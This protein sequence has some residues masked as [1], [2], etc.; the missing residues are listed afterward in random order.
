MSFQQQLTEYRSKHSNNLTDHQDT[1]DDGII[2]NEDLDEI[3]PKLNGDQRLALEWIKAGKNVLITGQAGT[4]KSMVLGEVIKWLEKKYGL[5]TGLSNMREEYAITSMTGISSVNIGGQTLHSWAGI[6]LAEGSVRD[7]LKTIERQMKTANWLT[8]RVLVIDEISMMSQDLFEKLHQVACILRKKYYH[9]GKKANDHLC[10]GI[11]L[12]LSGDFLQLPPVGDE[13]RFC[14]QS[15]VWQRFM[16]R[17]NVIHLTKIYRQGDYVFQNMLGRIRMGV[18][19]EDDRAILQSKVIKRMPKVSKNDLVLP[20]KLYPFRRDVEVINEQ[21]YQ[22]V[23]SRA[24]NLAER[25]YEPI[26]T[27]EIHEKRLGY[28]SISAAVSIMK[29]EEVYGLRDNLQRCSGRMVYEGLK[30]RENVRVKLCISAQVMLNYNLHVASGLANGVKGMVCGFDPNGNPMV[31]FDGFPAPIMIPRVDHIHNTEY[32]KLTITQYPLDLAWA[33]TIHKSQGLS[34]SKIIT[35]L[36]NVF[37]PGQSYVCLSR[38]KSLDGLYLMGIDY[39][40][41]QCNQV[42]KKFYYDLNYY[43]EYQY[44]DDCRDLMSTS[45]WMRHPKIC[46]HCLAYYMTI[47]VNELPYEINQIIVDFLEG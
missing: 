10:G 2:N 16:D 11:R 42:A 13:G 5:P 25:T 27:I 41:I 6:G 39:N 32:Y 21:E 28:K 22:E 9:D 20:T 34:L 23:L 4:G 26:Y 12:I 3:D 24:G 14:F 31:Q 36:N 17:S 47:W 43:C 8:I 29:R 44:V 37:S 18:V 1:T 45:S 40:K 19:T 35:N 15:E 38:V 33:T 7:I 46:D 30:L